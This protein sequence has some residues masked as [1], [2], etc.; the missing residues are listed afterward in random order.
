MCNFKNLNYI[1]RKYQVLGDKEPW[2]ITSCRNHS[3]VCVCVCL[4]NSRGVFPP[5][6]TLAVE[7]VVAESSEDAVNW[8]V[9]PLQAHGALWQLGQLHH[10]QTGSLRRRR[11]RGGGQRE[12][13]RCYF[14][15]K[16]NTTT[17]TTRSKTVV[18]IHFIT[19]WS[20]NAVVLP[21]THWYH[22]YVCLM[23]LFM[24]SVTEKWDS[25]WTEFT[26]SDL[27]TSARST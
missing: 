8:L 12:R 18:D 26:S 17:S 5:L 13:K 9:H 7:A 16:S 6:E 21:K 27:I 19:C 20:Q 14:S 11:Q 24:S 3:K 2:Y 25:P 10:R 1:S 15:S 4:H 23:S 22:L